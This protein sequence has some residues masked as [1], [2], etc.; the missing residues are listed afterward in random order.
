MEFEESSLLQACFLA[1]H[2]ASLLLF[3]LLFFFLLWGCTHGGDC[4]TTEPLT[5]SFTS[6]LG[7]V[8]ID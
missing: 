6:G 5:A 2:L 7:T 8:M 4:S 3:L 1:E